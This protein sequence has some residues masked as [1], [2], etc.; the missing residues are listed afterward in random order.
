VVFRSIDGAAVLVDFEESV[1][2]FGPPAWDLA[3]L[4]QRFCLCD[5]PSPSVGLQRLAVVA[6]AYGGPLPGLA[7]MMRQAAWFSMATIIDLRM[8]HGVVT[9]MDE[10]DKFVRLARQARAFEGVL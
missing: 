3:F 9:P 5:D 4:V 7:T 10:Y 6:E 8:S 2:V 1:H